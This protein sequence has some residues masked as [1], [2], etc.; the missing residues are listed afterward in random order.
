MIA[1]RRGNIHLYRFEAIMMNQ[2]VPLAITEGHNKLW[3]E[4]M[5]IS[6]AIICI[7]WPSWTWSMV[8]ESH[9]EH[10]CLV[11]NMGRLLIKAWVGKESIAG[12]MLTQLIEGCGSCLSFIDDLTW[13]TW[14]YFLKKSIQHL[15]FLKHKKLV[16]NQCGKRIIII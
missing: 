11:S 4:N 3:H 12:L 6:I 13:K 7:N 15:K 9:L 1:P 14:V 10:A 2:Q 5:G 16:E 8:S